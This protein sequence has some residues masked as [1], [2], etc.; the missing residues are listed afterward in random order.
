MPVQ[1]EID[2]EATPEEVWEAI[3]TEEGRERWLGEPG[4]EIDVQVEEEPHRL[5]W[6][7]R[8]GEDAPPTRVEFVIEAVP[9]GS[10]VVVV[11]SEP[12]LPVRMLAA[13]LALVA[14]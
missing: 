3:A 9:C 1:R 2:V 10:R 14:A 11:E 13:S 4:R 6:Q 7:W 8:E 12:V 5:V